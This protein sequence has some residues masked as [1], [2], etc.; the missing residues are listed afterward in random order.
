MSP[1]RARHN[2]WR[3]DTILTGAVFVCVLIAT[4]VSD[5]LNGP[6]QSAPG[7]LTGIL[8]AAATAF[9]VATGSDSSKK[10][11]DVKDTAE[12]AEAKADRLAEVAES[13]HPEAAE[14]LHP[15]FEGSA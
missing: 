5:W 7:Y 6:N 15:P 12:R 1:L 9:F 2:T 8:G 3:S 11:V 14:Q 4:V 10:E 13:Q